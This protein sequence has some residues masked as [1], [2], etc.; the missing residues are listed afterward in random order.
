LFRD[1]AGIIAQR[2]G[3]NA[4]TLRVYNTFDNANANSFE[5]GTFGW[6]A[7]ALQIGTEKGTVG[8]AA[9]PLSIITDGVERVNVGATGT[10]SVSGAINA[11]NGIL[12]SSQPVLNTTQTWSNS[13]V[14]FTGSVLNI[15]NTN[16]SA[17]SVIQEWQVNGVRS[18]ALQADA[19]GR[20][21]GSTI[22]S[23][24]TFNGQS[25][26]RM[27]IYA[28]GSMLCYLSPTDFGLRGNAAI[29]WDSTGGDPNSTGN[30]LSIMRDNQNHILGQ[31]ASANPQTSNVYNTYTDTSNYERGFSRWRGSQFTATISGTTMTLTVAAVG[32]FAVGQR[33]AGTGVTAGTVINSLASGT[34]G[35][36]GSTY[37]LSISQ[38]VATAT[39]MNSYSDVYEIGTEKLG[40]GSARALSFL[41]DGTSRWVIDTSG[42]L[43][44]QMAGAG[45]GVFSYFQGGFNLVAFANSTTAIARFYADSGHARISTTESSLVVEAPRLTFSG[46]TSLFPALKR[47]GTTLQ[48]RLADDSAYSVMDA[49][50][51]A[52][53]TAPATATSTGTA[54]DV[55]YDADYIYICTATNIWKR[56][57]LLTWV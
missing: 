29:R 37:T 36:V 26:N 42:R 51:R 6:G 1:A 8:G 22:N 30:G 18:L 46:T 17:S 14:A 35:A 49:Q 10:V 56:A 54:G 43:V 39:V 3:V 19:F 7:S 32:T 33:I 11:N 23:G 21:S 48:V 15:T 16:S 27:A 44:S 40:T 41:T 45:A 50:L 47:S 25:A 38:T 55:R 31:R 5:R 20:I 28:G 4:Q 34:L 13:A 52:Q 2:N 12:T 9:R 57:Q 53:G 24:F